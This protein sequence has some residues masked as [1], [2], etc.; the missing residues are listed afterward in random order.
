MVQMALIAKCASETYLAW[1]RK[2]NTILA[3]N[4]DLIA[5]PIGMV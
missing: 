5:L 4:E 3:T 1:W 2:D